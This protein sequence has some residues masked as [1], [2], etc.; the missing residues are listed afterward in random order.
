MKIMNKERP[1]KIK[2]IF[3]FSCGD[4]DNNTF[5]ILIDNRKPIQNY[6]GFIV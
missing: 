2:Q 4:P 5:I 6:T 3:I 1:R